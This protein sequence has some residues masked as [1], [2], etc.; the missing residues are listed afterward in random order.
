MVQ[1]PSQ[2]I[3]L[4]RPHFT[5]L[6]S[7]KSALHHQG[8]NVSNKIQMGNISS[9]ITTCPRQ[10]FPVLLLMGNFT[11]R[12][13]SPCDLSSNPQAFLMTSSW[14]YY[15]Q[16]MG[17]KNNQLIAENHSC[18]GHQDRSRGYSRGSLFFNMALFGN[19][20]FCT[21][22]LFFST[23]HQNWVIAIPPERSV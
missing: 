10:R 14:F 3:P 11:S 6:C 20:F 21:Q 22:Q 4:F 17:N 23:L 8:E 7:G 13:S 5:T 15:L 16:K 19:I 1:L 12:V 18:C 2:Y 9:L